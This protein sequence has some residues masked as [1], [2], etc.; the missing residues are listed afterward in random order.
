[1]I[2]VIIW[3]FYSMYYI[4]RHMFFPKKKDTEYI[5]YHE[6]GEIKYWESGDEMREYNEDGA[7]TKMRTK[8]R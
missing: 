2:W 7:L 6:N 8:K 4:F 5:E 1:M 3:V